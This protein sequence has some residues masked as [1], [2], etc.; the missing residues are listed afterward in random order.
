MYG[1]Q[2]H[3]INLDQSRVI[4]MVP[5]IIEY[6]SRGYDHKCDHRKRS[7]SVTYVDHKV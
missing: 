1:F 4:N 5:H 7:Q 3:V 2:S 6:Q